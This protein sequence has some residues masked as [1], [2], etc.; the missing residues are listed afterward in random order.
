MRTVA[1]NEKFITG[2]LRRRWLRGLA[3]DGWLC[4]EARTRPPAR[5]VVRLERMAQGGL[6]VRFPA[7][8]DPAKLSARAAAIVGRGGDL[9]VTVGGP[10][11][12]VVLR[13]EGTVVYAEGDPLHFGALSLDLRHSAR[14][15]GYAYLDDVSPEVKVEIAMDLDDRVRTAMLGP[16]ERIEHGPYT[17]EHVRSYDP[18]D[19]NTTL[20]NHAYFVRIERTDAA[21]APRPRGLPHPLDVESAGEVVRAART[22]G[23]LD[24]DEALVTE[25]ALLARCLSRYEGGAGQLEQALDD[26]GPTSPVL[27]RRGDAVS[28]HSARLARDDRGRA[29]VGQ[30]TI[31]LHP[32]GALQVSRLDVTTMPGR[33]RRAPTDPL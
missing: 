6:A 15:S 1:F 28:V 10:E 31:V 2:R 32:T 29:V 23:A 11:P 19:R 12:L 9:E 18:S 21:I 27:V 4:D 7:A 8:S 16:G 22:A 17:I 25:P 13:R 30:A 20:R 24:D 26:C 33:M 3:I 14:R 5:A